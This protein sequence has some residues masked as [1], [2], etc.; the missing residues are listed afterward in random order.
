MLTR[1][2]EMDLGP[3]GIT[4]NAVAPGFILTDMAKASRGRRRPSTVVDEMSARAMVRRVGQPDDVAHAVAFLASD[5]AG[6]VTAQ[7]LTVDADGWTI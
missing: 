2:F 5:S 4:V 6:F 3:H 1:R 7:V